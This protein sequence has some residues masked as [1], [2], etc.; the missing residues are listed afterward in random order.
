MAAKLAATLSKHKHVCRARRPWMGV[1]SD[2]ALHSA[3][4]RSYTHAPCNRVLSPTG[5]RM[6]QWEASIPELNASKNSRIVDHWCTRSQR[7][8]LGLV[9]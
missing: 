5:S 8:S 2:C 1:S 6:L 4:T 9:P 7:C 3:P